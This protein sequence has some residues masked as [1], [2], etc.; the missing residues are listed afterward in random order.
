MFNSVTQNMTNALDTFVETGKFNFSN[1]AESIIK[2][3]I[4][5]QLRMQMMKLFSMGMGMMMGGGGFMNEAG[6]MEVAGSLGFAD[7]GNP[8]VG[9]PSIV[10]ERGPELFVPNRA[11]TIVPNHQLKQVLGDTGGT[12]VNGPCIQNMNAIDTQS[13]VQFLAKNKMTIWSMNQSA[14]RSI[15]AGR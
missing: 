6:G 2:D 9:V 15:P 4:K 10:G 12:T 7:G 11:G 14:N 1:F 5:I 8:P 3:L 13:V